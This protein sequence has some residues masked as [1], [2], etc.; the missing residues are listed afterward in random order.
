MSGEYSIQNGIE[1]PVCGALAEAVDVVDFNKCCEEVRGLYFK[2]SGYPVYYA[3]C[4][5]C[6]FCFAPE[7]CRW[8]INDFA[9]NIYNSEYSKVDPD[10][11][12]V[13]PRNNAK[14]VISM[15]ENIKFEINH[16]DYGGGSGLLSQLLKESGWASS[17]YDPFV[18]EV[19]SVG[20]LGQFDLIT[21]FEVFEHVPD[22]D[23]LMD[24]LSDLLKYD[25]VILFSTLLSDN[26]ISRNQRLGWW[27]ASPRNG[28]ISLFS[29]KSLGIISSKIGLNFGSFSEG[30]HMFW[31][32]NPSWAQHLFA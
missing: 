4:D 3:L 23:Q 24:N 15:F 11:L 6:G 26:N 18:D 20:A 27:Y 5:E 12:D 16:L 9:K 17:S 22:I 2:I 8:S 7:L 19:E 21:A 32:G 30:F 13:R 31:R 25:G 14:A 10:Y 28:H 1:C 29:K